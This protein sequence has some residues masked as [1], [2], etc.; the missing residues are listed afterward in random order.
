MADNEWVVKVPD[1]LEAELVESQ[2]GPI[3]EGELR[4]L[5]EQLVD[6][7]HGLKIEIFSNEHPPPHLGLTMREKLQITLLKTVG[8]SMEDFPDGIKI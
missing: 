7:L 8:K 2:K 4:L 1:E 3:I 5:E 6:H